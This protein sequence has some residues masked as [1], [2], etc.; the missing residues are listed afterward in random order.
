ML[1]CIAIQSFLFRLLQATAF[2]PIMFRPIN[3]SSA[4]QPDRLRSFAVG[5]WLVASGALSAQTPLNVCTNGFAGIYPCSGIDLMGHLSA[6]Q[7]GQPSSVKLNDVW[8][9]TDPSTDKEYALVGMMPGTAFVEVTDPTAPVY[10]GF[11]PTHTVSSDWR[12]IKTYSN[13]CFVVSEATGHGLQVFD[14]TRLRG[15]TGPPV[16]FTA[17]AHHNGFGR[18]HNLAIN[19][20]SGFAYVVG[21]SG[22]SGG[23]YMVD[24]RNPKQPAY[25]GCF[26]ADGYTHDAQIVMYNGPD[27][28]RSGREIAFACNEDTL[29]IVDVTNKTAPF[30]ISRTGYPGAAYSHQGWLTEDHRY[31]IMNDE[32]DEQVFGQL[33]RTHMWDVS[34]LEN[35]MYLGFHEH[36]TLAIDHNLYLHEGLVYQANYRAGL[37]VLDTSPVPDGKLVPLGFFDIYPANDLP[38][39]NGA[40]SV[41][42]FFESGTVLL[43]GI[44]QGLFLLRLD[45]SRLQPA[46]LRCSI[47][48][49]ENPLVTTNLF[50]WT[51]TI[52][53]DGPSDSTQ[54]T[55]E[56]S[57][58]PPLQPRYV[59]QGDPSGSS[60]AFDGNGVGAEWDAGNSWLSLTSSGASQE[61]GMY[62]SVVF[63]AGMPVDWR[64]IAWTP[65]LPYGKPLPD[66]AMKDVGYPGGDSVGGISLLHHPGSNQPG[67]GENGAHLLLHFDAPSMGDGGLLVDSS[68]RGNSGVLVSE[69]PHNKSV[70]GPFGG[71][72]TLDGINDRVVFPEPVFQANG[73]ALSATFTAW[74]NTQSD[75][76]LFDQPDVSPDLGFQLAIV[77]GHLQYKRGGLNV[78]STLA[79]L[80]NG[81]WRHVAFTRD[82][83]GL[84][85]MFVDGEESGTGVDVLP[86]SA[87][88]G[89]LGALHAGAGALAALIDEMALFQA[90]LTPG[91]IRALYVRG[92]CSVEFQVRRC[93]TPSC[94]DAEWIG[95]DGTSATYFSEV[96]N[97]GAELPRFLLPPA[98]STRYA[99][100][101]VRLATTHPALRPS[102]HSVTLGPAHLD[103]LWGKISIPDGACSGHDPMVCRLPPIAPHGEVLIRLD[104]ILPPLLPGAFTSTVHAA[105]FQYDPFPSNNHLEAVTQVPDTNQNGVP[106]FLDPDD[107]G[108][109]FSDLH[110]IWLGTNPRDAS[111]RLELRILRPTSDENNGFLEYTAHTNVHYQLEV[112]DN[113]DWTPFGPLTHTSTPNTPIRTPIPLHASDTFRLKAE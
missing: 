89:S 100:Y 6:M 78:V 107:D 88:P 62:T 25:A 75:G 57:L 43:S 54:G 90:E 77:G 16:T 5:L 113:G 84:V 72:I 12:D 22:C 110:E 32:S 105:G 19:E 98:L 41:Y 109:G 51:I 61:S 63:D 91:Q 55:L 82:V 13:H 30:Q 64:S 26:S 68:G 71:A 80:H 112:L 104:L 74:I 24:I 27:V 8:G 14:L 15:L 81:Q 11:L 34:N 108:D 87:L 106:D 44:E 76:I 17:D 40:W 21:G 66:G 94:S 9:W 36:N 28:A 95:P 47:V 85:R 56:I 38:L 37:H 86:W 69:D 48:A 33:T 73:G 20:D 45:P 42:P 83:N 39:F 3:R 29:T 92:A 2:P 35:P 4:P 60:G 52:S 67:K 70:A 23:L 59:R 65:H 46:N 96:D 79:D 99:Q 93:T 1:C 53:N 31:F 97:P 10:L 7:M 102:L 49:D 103:P 18:A 111:S 58:P 101:R 50:G